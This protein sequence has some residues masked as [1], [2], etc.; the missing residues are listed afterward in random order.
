MLEA[1]CTGL[2][3][4]GRFAEA[5]DAGLAA[6]Q[7]EVLRE[8]AHRALITAYLAEGNCV[9]AIRQYRFF[10]ELLRTQLGLEPSPLMSELVAPLHVS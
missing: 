5:A 6:V 4:A 3:A 9:E 1:L 8:S 10:R 2:A 7:G